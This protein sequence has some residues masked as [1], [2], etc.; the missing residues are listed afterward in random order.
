METNYTI[1]NHRVTCAHWVALRYSG[2]PRRVK[3]DQ[4]D[5]TQSVTFD[6]ALSVKLRLGRRDS[7]VVSLDSAFSTSVCA[8]KPLEAAISRPISLQKAEMWEEK[9]P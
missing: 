7:L 9:K 5:Q 8:V 4:A 2:S 6:D 3:S 1:A